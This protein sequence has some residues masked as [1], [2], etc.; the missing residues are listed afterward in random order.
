MEAASSSERLNPFTFSTI[1]RNSSTKI[2]VDSTNPSFAPGRTSALSPNRG[3]TLAGQWGRSV[4][5]SNALEGHPEKPTCDYVCLLRNAGWN[6]L[7]S[8]AT[9]LPPPGAGSRCDST[10]L[11]RCRGSSREAAEASEFSGSPSPALQSRRLSLRRG[12]SRTFR[13]DAP[14][15]RAGCSCPATSP[16]RS[17]AAQRQRGC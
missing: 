14:P 15:G 12:R 3:A 13:A 8:P 7:S 1:G 11:H 17:T 6:P 9:P 16:S 4:V 5:R 2:S 10:V